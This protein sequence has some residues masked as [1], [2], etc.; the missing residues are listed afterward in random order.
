MY[1]RI[2]DVLPL[3]VNSI[4]SLGRDAVQPI[5]SG[6][7]VPHSLKYPLPA[8]F[9]TPFPLYLLALHVWCATYKPIHKVTPVSVAALRVCLL[10]TV[11]RWQC[12]YVWTPLIRGSLGCWEVDNRLELLI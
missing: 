8:Y 10:M 11:C 12:A 6:V 2:S 7:E 9:A 4:S 3:S 1:D 5:C